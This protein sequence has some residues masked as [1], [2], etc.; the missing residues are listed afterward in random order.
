MY[1]Q[2]PQTTRVALWKKWHDEKYY[3]QIT[4][5][6]QKLGPGWL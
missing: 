4:K 5:K 1:E 2:C 3:G 6:A